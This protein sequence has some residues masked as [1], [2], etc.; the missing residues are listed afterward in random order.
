MVL[1]LQLPSGLQSVLLHIPEL[2]ASRLMLLLQ[3]VL[4][5]VLLHAAA[6]PDRL[7]GI[8]KSRSMNPSAWQT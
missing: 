8:L 3:L 7:A 1:V 4:V 6:G 5:V 2:W